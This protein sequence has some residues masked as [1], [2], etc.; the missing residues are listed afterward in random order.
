[1][2]YGSVSIRLYIFAH[3]NLRTAFAL[4]IGLKLIYAFT[5]ARVLIPRHSSDGISPGGYVGGGHLL[6]VLERTDEWQI[7]FVFLHGTFRDIKAN[8]LVGVKN[9]VG[10]ILPAVQDGMS[11][12]NEWKDVAV[13]NVESSRLAKWCDQN[14]LLIGDAAHV[15]SPVGGVGI[16]YAIQHAIVTAGIVGPALLQIS[17]TESHLAKVQKK[18]IWP[19]RVV[20]WFQGG[21]QKRIV[22]AA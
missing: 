2:C 19:T 3:N 1:M 20:Q 6:I 9:E 12:I 13:L 21:L 11:A 5:C 22:R 14:L 10:A 7:G 16:N 18:R 8:G 15:M 17:L 4:R